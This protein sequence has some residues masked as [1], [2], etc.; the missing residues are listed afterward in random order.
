MELFGPAYFIREWG[1]EIPAWTDQPAVPFLYGLIFRLLGE[2][3]TFIQAFTTVLFSLSAAITY[4]IGK[5]LWDRETGAAA[6]WLFLGIPYLFTQPP[7]MLVDVPTMFFFILSV[8]S[9][10]RAI[11]APKLS[12]WAAVSG[13]AIFL[14]LFSKY[15]TW[16]MLS[17]LP[18][19]FGIIAAKSRA[20]KAIFR[21]AGAVLLLSALFSLSF[22]LLKWDVILAQLKF[23]SSYQ[24]PGL[25]RWGESFRST[26]LFQVHP[27]IT[28]FALFSFYRAL[29]TRDL[30]F[31]I[32]A[33]LPVLVLAAGVRRIRYVIMV[34]PMLALMASFG[35]AAIKSAPARRF[36]VLSVLATSLSLGLGGFLP[37]LVKESLVNL[38]EAGAFLDKTRVPGVEVFTLNTG[39][40]VNPAV[41][42]PTLDLHTKKDIHYHY[43]DPFSGTGL[44]EDLRTSPFRFTW[45][46]RNPSYYERK[47]LRAGRAVAVIA[48]GRDVP[49]PPGMQKKI[50]GL[51]KTARFESAT[52]IFRYQTFVTVYLP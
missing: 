4:L 47:A 15:S 3:R 22:A 6:G 17:V 23:L 1:K 12:F 21:N 51:K 24:V 11:E 31:L 46:Y 32:A 40:P 49:L 36:I 43:E 14:T 33:F 18:V 9:F 29:K 19:A 42:V 13:A 44:P 25:R 37:Y 41:A 30:K 27:F 48:T 34:F 45:E 38:K 26:F 28:A 20:R 52:G 5:H 39:S 2:S 16:M 8:Y 35:L 7:L 50:A 10:I